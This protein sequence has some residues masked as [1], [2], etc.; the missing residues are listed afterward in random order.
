MLQNETPKGTHKLQIREDFIFYDLSGKRDCRASSLNDA[1]Q[2]S[3]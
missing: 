1:L 2:N 3:L